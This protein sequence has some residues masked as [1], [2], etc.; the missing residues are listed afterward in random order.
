MMDTI[1]LHTS[2][3]HAPTKS[4]RRA[5]RCNPVCTHPWTVWRE[6]GGRARVVH[7]REKSKLHANPWRFK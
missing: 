4:Y 5:P 3:A 6:F 2:T 7:T 1:G